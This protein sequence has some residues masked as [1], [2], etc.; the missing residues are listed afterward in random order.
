MRYRVRALNRTAEVI[1]LDLDVETEA[2]ARTAAERQGCSVLSVQPA[3]GAARIWT[4]RRRFSTL[5][6]SVELLA[7]LDAGINL[8]E[9]LRALA[10]KESNGET[11]QVIAG[12]L[13]SL[14][15]GE[16]FS[17][18]IERQPEH[19]APLYAAT[20]RSSERTGD[21]ADALK[22]YVAYAEEFDRLRKKVVSALVYPAILAIVGS[23]V[24]L[25]LMLYVVPR[26]ARVYEDMRTELPFFSALLLKLG[27]AVG[28]H[29]WIVMLLLAGAAGGIAWAVTDTNVRARVNAWLWDIPS[30]GERMKVFQLGRL[31]RTTGM[32]LM[33][34]T[35]LVRALDMTSGLLAPHLR[36]ALARSRTLL[37]EGQSASMAFGATGLTTPI[38][39]RMIAV[40]E[41]SGRLG[42]MMSRVARFYDDE[43]A[44]A[45]DVFI[46][47]FEPLLM[48]VLGLAVGAVV[49]MMYMPIFELAG[50][51]Q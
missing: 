4:T 3:G 38:A 10:E 37:E 31:Y 2:G 20:V 17:R 24:L 25:F 8:V 40:G 49:V 21:L 7:L 29:G 46:R 30:L 23:L 43:T 12:L 14:E 16:S 26:F 13:E 18:A 32:L 1:E 5:L 48:A 51:I 15:Q 28:A 33:A 47:A 9:A 22:R 41:K 19:F 39:T 6:F 50:S 35:P 44:R 34:G 36:A 27:S 42:E 11:R 45:L